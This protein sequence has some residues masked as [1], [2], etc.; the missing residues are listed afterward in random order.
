M[1]GGLPSVVVVDSVG[2]PVRLLVVDLFVFV[3]F[4]GFVWFN[5]VG[6][7]VYFICVWLVVLVNCNGLVC[8]WLL[9]LAYWVC[10]LVLCLLLFVAGLGLIALV[11]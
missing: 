1:V 2:G 9:S 7:I 4:V 6:L 10:I 11:L 8:G 3:D 5:S